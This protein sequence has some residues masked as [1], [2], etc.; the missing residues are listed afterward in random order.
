VETEQCME[1]ILLYIETVVGIAMKPCLEPFRVIDIDIDIPVK[2]FICNT[3]LLMLLSQHSFYWCK[4]YRVNVSQIATG[5]GGGGRRNLS[6]SF[7]LIRCGVS[8]CLSV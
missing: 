2:E 7:L 5:V 4:R 8:R 3:V 6:G 1:G